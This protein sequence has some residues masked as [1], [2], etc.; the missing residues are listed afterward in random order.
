MRRR[1]GIWGAS[2]ESL[3]LLRLL[4]GNP[5]VEV[6]RIYDADVPAA[7]E[8]ARGLGAEVSHR[9]API[10]VAPRGPLRRVAATEGC[11]RS[12]PGKVEPTK[13]YEQYAEKARRSPAFAV[14]RHG[15]SWV[16]PRQP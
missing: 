14:L 3:R 7:L 2:E 5:D 13:A 4:A 16:T 9:I 8:R 12:R 1:L 15:A 11:A 10:L 6:D